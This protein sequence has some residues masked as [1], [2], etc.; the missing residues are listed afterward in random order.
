MAQV[1]KLVCHFTNHSVR[2]TMC[3]QL[4]HAGVTPNTIANN[5]ASVN[6]YAIASKDMQKD[7]CKI[8]CNTNDISNDALVP[9]RNHS[10]GQVDLENVESPQKEWCVRIIFW[11]KY[12]WGEFYL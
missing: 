11:G 8:L 3:T 4:L 12:R 5:M 2:K 10:K 6:N 9:Y 1:A 7:M